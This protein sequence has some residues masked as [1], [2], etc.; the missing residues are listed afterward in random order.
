MKGLNIQG[1]S[2]GRYW[3]SI[4]DI[5]GMLSC[6]ESIATGGIKVYGTYMVIAVQ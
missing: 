2:N 4:V 3:K 6:A 5:K 1:S